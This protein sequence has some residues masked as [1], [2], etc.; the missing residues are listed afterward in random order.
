M[1]RGD[2]M[3]ILQIFMVFAALVNNPEIL[4]IFESILHLVGRE[5]FM[6]LANQMP[7]HSPHSLLNCLLSKSPKVVCVDVDF[8]DHKLLMRNLFI[9]QKEITKIFQNGYDA[10]ESSD[11]D[12]EVYE[13]LETVSSNKG[14]RFFQAGDEISLFLPRNAGL[15][16]RAIDKT[17]FYLMGA[18]GGCVFMITMILHHG[19]MMAGGVGITLLIF[20]LIMMAPLSTIILFAISASLYN[21][22]QP[23][24]LKLQP[25]LTS[26]STTLQL[27]KLFNLIKSSVIALRAYLRGLVY[28]K[29]PSSYFKIKGSPRQVAVIY[30][31]ALLRYDLESIKTI[32]NSEGVVIKMN[33]SDDINN[34]EVFKEVVLKLM[35]EFVHYLNTKNVFPH[36]KNQQDGLMTAFLSKRSFDFNRYDL[37]MGWIIS[38]LFSVED[39]KLFVVQLQRSIPDDSRRDEYLGYLIDFRNGECPICKEPKEDKII[40]SGCGHSFHPKCLHGSN[41]CPEC[42]TPHPLRTS[43]DAVWKQQPQ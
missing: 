26:I 38:S 15:T 12:P 8:D 7:K 11:R 32:V 22:F 42:R 39:L 17:L 1:R 6:N 9:N 10:L 18:F 23:L 27:D 24:I 37:Q 41:N 13:I 28:I 43:A 25:T 3:I 21:I 30:G 14:I 5:E 16:K 33:N 36:F 34:M 31:N 35:Y 40:V 4:D 19:A 29:H 2:T 20:S